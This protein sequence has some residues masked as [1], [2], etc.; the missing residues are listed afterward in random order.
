MDLA[1]NAAQWVVGKALAPV[2]D[3]LLQSWAGS[4]QLGPNMEALRME[5]LLVKATL[6]NAGDK[7]LDGRQALEELLQKMQD[8]AHNAEDVLDELDYFRIH[9]ELYG[10]CDA[11]NEDTRGCGHNVLLNARHTAKAVGKLLSCTSASTSGDHVEEDATHR[12]L[13]CA[14]PRARERARGSSSSAAGE[15]VSSRMSK[16]GKF[17]PCSSI[18]KVHDDDD[19]GNS[20]LSGVHARKVPQ[21]NPANETTI[22]RFHRVDV[23]NRMKQIVEQLRPMRQEV[24]TILRD[25][26]LRIAAGPAHNRPTTT[27]ESLEPKLHGRDHMLNSIIHDITKGKYCGKDLTVLPL[28]GPGGIG[29]TTLTQYIHNA[30]EVQ[31]HF[32]VVV[33]TCVSLDF[34]PNK[35]LEEIKGKI[36]NVEGEKEGE[37]G[38]VIEQRL[39]SKRLLLILDDMWKC[40]DQEDWERWLLPFKKS[41]TKGSMILVT[42]RFQALAE[43][44]KTTGRYIKLGGLEPQEFRKLFLAYIFGD[45]DSTEDHTYLLETGDKIIEKLK[46]SPLAAK[47]VGRLLR[48]HLDLHHWKM[49]LE[50]KEWET[51]TGNHDIMPA[52]KLSYDYLPFDIKQCFSYSALFPEDYKFHSKQLIHFWIGLDI[53]HSS[54]ET[55][56]KE[57]IGLRNL[58]YLVTHGFFRKEET[59]GEPYY[60]IHDLLHNLALKIA[61]HECLSLNFPNVRSIG[62]HPCTRHLSVIIDIVDCDKAMASENIETELRKLKTRF[63]VEKLQT[64]MVFGE[65]D[66][67]IASIFGDFLREANALRVL[68]FSKMCIPVESMLHNFSTLVH[69]RYLS[70]GTM[71]K[72]YLPDTISRFYHLKILDL[73]EWC[74]YHD[75]PRDMSNLAKLCHI[76]TQ[77]D[78]LH[79]CI[80]NV[81]KLKLL[82]ELKAF[83]VNKENEGFEQK[84]LEDLVELRELGIY[85]LEKIHTQEEAAKAKLINKNYLRVLT[86]SWDSEQTNAKPEDEGLVL[87]SLQPHRNLQE[88]YIRGNKGPSCPTWL[89]DKLDVEALKSLHLFRVSWDVFPSFGKMWDLR[90][91]TLN[92]ISTIKEFGLE[93]SLCKLLKKITLTGLENFEKWVPQPTHFFPHLQV[94]II[95]DCPKL[96]EL[97]FSCHIVYPLKQDWNTDWFPKLQELKIE[98]C[99]EVLLLPPIPW[100]QSLCFVKINDV[101]SKLLHDLVYSKSSSGVALNIHGKDGLLS[102]DQLLLFSQLTE[103][104]ELNIYNSPPLELKYFLMLTSLKTLLAW[105]S[106]LGVVPS[107]VQSGVEW[108]H[109]VDEIKIWSSDSS[110]KELSQFLSHLPKLSKLEVNSCKN[111]TQLA[112]GVDLQ[113]TTVPVVSSSISLDVITMDDTQTQVKVEQQE[114]AEVEKEE[115][116]TVDDDGLLL[117]PAH[118]SNSLQELA[119]DSGNLV[120]H[121]LNALKALTRLELKDC[122]FRHPFPSCLLDLELSSV[123]GVLTLSNLT[124]LTRLEIYRCGEDFRCEGLL[125]LLT[126]GHLSSLEVIGSPNFFGGWEWDPNAMWGRSSKLQKVETDDIQ[127][128]LGAPALCS[129]LSSSLSDLHFSWNDETAHFTN[130]QEEAF[131]CLTSLQVLYFWFCHKLEHLP[132]ALNKLTNLKRLVICGC[133]ALR[134]LPKD[135]LP[136]SLRELDVEDCVNKEL[137]E[138]C[139]RLMG[140]IPKIRL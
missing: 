27:S 140:T 57:D 96:S 17:F 22:L 102:F 60:I 105:S 9:D 97:P 95:I 49:V 123:E 70:L 74:G 129:L 131:Q 54:G 91:L 12:V 56:T 4:N 13:C 68:F 99:P 106:N 84:Q 37:V 136:S 135:G 41:Q 89:G 36:P 46:G 10:T 44:V 33:W 53:L 117:L 90:E 58:N 1:L 138:H 69:L 119:I 50:S 132:A 76:P 126:R 67:S 48:D 21:N 25:C 42:T 47:T 111:I 118:L 23:S 107:E 108:Q 81:G 39:K 125:P 64:L 104:Q 5:L 3:G 63:S 112:V 82:Q 73:E 24:T 65:M 87:E 35:L 29:K 101:G 113:Q 127:G 120:V 6:E 15:E 18:P 116:N 103:L 31:N 51:Q 45:E 130:E 109:P 61:S 8:L 40:G 139:R 32:E 98:N 34:N 38:K 55:R 128:F 83:K 2:A 66:E 16:F 122:S 94:L 59:S 30:Q 20:I 7:Q 77:R 28:V 71:L 52:L 62:I 43:T 114:I 134:S 11:A 14:P 80:Y 19:S 78:E 100:T 85:N 88:L 110:G 133:P 79:S 124:S 115:A 75:V 26:R 93:E 72:M 92:H 121:S 137:T 86:L